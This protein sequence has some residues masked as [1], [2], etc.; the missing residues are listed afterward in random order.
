M[1]AEINKILDRIKNKNEF[2]SFISSKLNKLS[3]YLPIINEEDLDLNEV[4]VDFV[5][6]NIL[7]KQ[8][9]YTGYYL[10]L[11]ILFRTFENLNCLI[12][13]IIL[14]STNQVRFLPLFYG[15]CNHSE[16]GL[17][18]VISFVSC[19]DL[20][21]KDETINNNMIKEL[22]HMYHYFSQRKISLSSLNLESIGIIE[23]N[24]LIIKNLI[25]VTPSFLLEYFK[26]EI[27]NSNIQSMVNLSND[28]IT[29]KNS[30]D[31]KVDIS[32]FDNL[33]FLYFLTLSFNAR[34][35][36]ISGNLNTNDSKLNCFKTKKKF[37]E[38]DT[39]IFMP[40]TNN[41]RVLHSNYVERNK[42]DNGKTIENYESIIIS[43]EDMSFKINNTELFGIKVRNKNRES[44]LS[45]ISWNFTIFNSMINNIYKSSIFNFT[46]N[47]SKFFV[48][49]E[50][51]KINS[52]IYNSLK[53]LLKENDFIEIDKSLNDS[54]FI[55]NFTLDEV[56]AFNNFFSSLKEIHNKKFYASQIYKIIN[57]QIA[58]NDICSIVLKL[59]KEKINFNISNPIFGILKKVIYIIMSC[60]IR[61]TNL[62]FLDSINLGYQI[63]TL[64]DCKDVYYNCKLF[65]KINFKNIPNLIEKNNVKIINSLQIPLQIKNFLKKLLKSDESRITPNYYLSFINTVVKEENE[66]NIDTTSLMNSK[67]DSNL[68]TENKTRSFFACNSINNTIKN[69]KLSNIF[70]QNN[71]LNRNNFE[72]KLKSDNS[73][74]NPQNIIS[75]NDNLSVFNCEN[76]LVIENK[77]TF[78]VN[79]KEDFFIIETINN[80]DLDII[81]DINYYLQKDNNINLKEHEN[82]YKEINKN[83]LIPKHDIFIEDNIID[84]KK[85]DIF[86]KNINEIE[87][88]LIQDKISEKCKDLIMFNIDNYSIT[89][90]MRNENVKLL[91]DNENADFINNNNNH[92]FID[93]EQINFTEI[94]PNLNNHKNEYY[95]PSEISKIDKNSNVLNHKNNNPFD[96]EN[97]NQNNKDNKQDY[98]DNNCI[99]NNNS[100]KIYYNKQNTFSYKKNSFNN[101]KISAISSVNNVKI[102]SDDEINNNKVLEE[103]FTLKNNENSSS[104]C[105][106]VIDHKNSIENYTT[107]LIDIFTVNENKNKNKNILDDNITSRKTL[108]YIKDT[109][110]CKI[111]ESFEQINLLSEKYIKNLKVSI[112]EDIEIIV[113]NLDY[114]IDEDSLKSIS[115]NSF[116]ALTCLAFKVLDE[117]KIK[118][119][120]N[121]SSLLY[122]IYTTLSFNDNLK[123][124]YCL[125][126][127]GVAVKDYSSDY[128][129]S[130]DILTKCTS[131]LHSSGQS[132]TKIGVQSKYYYGCL[133]DEM[134]EHDKAFNILNDVLKSQINLHSD[135]RGDNEFL[136]SRDFIAKTYNCLGICEDNRRNLKS[137]LF[138]YNKAYDLF[139]KI[140]EGVETTD[141]GKALNNIAGIFY[142]WEDYKKSYDLYLRVLNIHI[143]FYG[144]IHMYTAMTYN[145]LAN[146]LVCLNDYS[147]AEKYFLKSIKTYRDVLGSK[148]IQAGMA[149][150]NLGDMFFYQ[151]KY[152]ESLKYLNES[153]EILIE[154]LEEDNDTIL[155][156]KNKLRKINN[157]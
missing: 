101:D 10:G 84:S 112:L 91:N 137:A 102:K 132:N 45:E 131:L 19:R 39:S 156:I 140:S 41:D 69:N 61:Y 25:N 125:F 64:L 48:N 138:Y 139:K 109:E 124:A 80:T 72:M 71:V 152:K 157:M 128:K 16:F 106:S 50:F 29:S 42:S 43:D 92:I 88:I 83:T 62:D 2:N 46:S 60:Y 7:L 58:M 54:F 59:T 13:E 114:I 33:K 96:S 81:K 32:S 121:V 116:N 90:G 89:N 1:I 153:L 23:N 129:L 12:S 136:I 3:D 146:T 5:E 141:C 135:K 105:T 63:L 93:V 120:Y 44:S 26:S 87:S 38:D 99:I 75:K 18:I 24:K 8:T 22:I 103:I 57:I 118:I 108:N 148:N 40:N 155:S 119:H 154:N 123:E 78:T 126:H 85:D 49:Y 77:E 86:S 95:N 130:L 147:Q 110:S 111:I 37:I 122:K 73:A 145:N 31:I 56:N 17:G 127:Y 27:N 117:E 94:D 70:N 144:E 113:N 133:L 76:S 34:F 67:N 11:N 28:R 30:Y 98:I 53:G 150:K 15:I 20:K 52:A 142:N 36:F 68:F 134:G 79:N 6:D 35:N 47:N 66:F 9:D 107:N 151:E 97:E 104:S 21:N 149:L 14:R 51:L 65:D 74:Y 82:E 100:S 143:Q 115:M 55:I 4:A